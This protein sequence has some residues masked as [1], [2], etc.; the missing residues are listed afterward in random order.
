MKVSFRGKPSRLTWYT[1]MEPFLR[2][3]CSQPITNIVIGCD[4]IAQLEEN[5][6]YVSV[7]KRMT[8][9]EQ[10][11]LINEAAPIA[12]QLM[13]Y[14]PLPEESIWTLKCRINV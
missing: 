5:V 2:F 11:M 7:F 6:N 14:K 8:A 12:R 10:L 1:S 3:A 9:E 4:D 13:H